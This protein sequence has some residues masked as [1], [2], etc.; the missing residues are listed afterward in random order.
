MK[1]QFIILPFIS[2]FFLCACQSDSSE[3]TS[4]SES[5]EATTTSNSAYSEG[6][7]ETTADEKMSSSGI[8]ETHCHVSELISDE[9]ITINIDA[10]VA[11][12]QVDEL[13]YYSFENTAVSSEIA[14][15]LLVMMSADMNTVDISDTGEWYR[16][17]FYSSQNPAEP[18]CIE[19]KYYRLGLYGRNDNLCPYGSNAYDEPNT[20][21]LSEYSA[22]NAVEECKDFYNTITSQQSI[23]LNTIP[24]GKT[25]GEDYY[26]ISLAPTVDNIPVFSK[27]TGINFDFSDKG[28]YNAEIELFNIVKGDI[29]S[30]L[31]SVSDCIEQMRK[32]LD[33]INLFPSPEIYDIYEY[34]V[35]ETGLLSNINI[36]KVE[37]AYVVNNSEEGAYELCPAWV[38]I[39]GTSE[40]LD[41]SNIIAVNVV[42]GELTTVTV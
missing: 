4:E 37:L 39:P 24:Y 29:I 32:Q 2:I 6:V 26:K 3:V 22:E 11:E 23:L 9:R 17:D 35:D 12:T 40:L 1:K 41:Y 42:T 34:S 15:K 13:F 20:E 38:F 8:Y 10:D 25:V 16:C 19:N 36:Q 5:I 33:K 7:T 14:D 28:I 31:L 30:E 18:Y 27:Y 21:I